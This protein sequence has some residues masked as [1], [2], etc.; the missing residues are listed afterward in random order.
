MGLKV[1]LKRA[2]EKEYRNKRGGKEG[3]WKTVIGYPLLL[4]EIN[5][6]LEE[7]YYNE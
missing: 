1:D 2:T 5:R 6:E 4:T 7:A 3:A